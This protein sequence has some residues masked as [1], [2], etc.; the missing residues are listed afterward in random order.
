M[1][2]AGAAGMAAA[3]R[4][5]R[6]S[7]KSA[8]TI[9]ESSS[10][11]ARGT[12]SLPYL[13]SRELSPPSMLVGISREE[14]S[15]RQIHLHLNTSAQ[16]IDPRGKV[17]HTEA[18]QHAYDKLIVTVGSRP[19]SLPTVGLQP[20]PRIWSL[21]TLADVAHIEATMAAVKAKKVAVV[22]GGYVGLEFAEALQ[23]RNLSVT[24]FHAGSTLAKL[25]SSCSRRLISYIS[26][27]GITVRLQ[28]RVELLEPASRTHTL[29][30]KTPDGSQQHEGFDA[31][32]LALGIEPNVDLMVSAGARS[33]DYGGIPVSLRGETSL[34]DVYAAGDGVELPSPLGG[35]RRWVPLAT[36]AARLGRVCGENAAGGS[37]RL[38]SVHGTLAL[39]IFDLQLGMV[40]V[41]QDWRESQAL[42]FQ[43]GKDQHEFSNRRSGEGVLFYEERSGRITGGHFLA[44]QA[45]SL[46]DI[47]SIG[48]AQ[49]MTIDDFL[50][51][52]FSYN[53]PL[54]PLWHPLYLAARQRQK[55]ALGEHL[56]DF[57]K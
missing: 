25:H 20:H 15:S 56:G 43:W 41:P 16:A 3:T 27:R 51:Q 31:I 2:G 57:A 47:V 5:R 14:L 26:E 8:I 28:T 21:R 1:I 54:A 40:G 36:A 34:P 37:S 33:G 32:A 39:R 52:D 29:T 13:L 9:L 30:W 10:E 7:P 23:R 22:G 6:T 48:I 12:C 42:G 50:E 17:V 46:S 45:S 19:R 53:P 44:P 4:A 35:N 38:G 24:L 55:L 11:Y 18:G 49:N